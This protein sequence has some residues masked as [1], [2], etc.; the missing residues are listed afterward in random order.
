MLVVFVIQHRGVLRTAQISTRPTI[1]SLIPLFIVCV[2]PLLAGSV[3]AT[4]FQPFTPLATENGQIVP[5]VWD[6]VGVRLFLGGLFIAA[7]SA[8]AFE[9]AVCT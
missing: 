9:T 7:W 3:H 4:N 2:I 6:K 5:S 8:Y 1:A